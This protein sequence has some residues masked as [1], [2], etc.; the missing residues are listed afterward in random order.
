MLAL[1]QAPLLGVLGKNRT[2]FTQ[3]TCSLEEEKKECANTIQG[4]KGAI[5]EGST[6]VLVFEGKLL[7]GKKTS[8]LILEGPE[9]SSGVG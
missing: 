7:K 9:S 4:I 2:P 8:Q 6:L 3:G 5:A 1:Y